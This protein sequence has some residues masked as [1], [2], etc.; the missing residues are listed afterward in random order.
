VSILYNL[1][2]NVDNVNISQFAYKK[3]T[4]TN[5]AYT[6]NTRKRV[7]DEC[8]NRFLQEKGGKSIVVL[9]NKN[10]VKTQD[11]KLIKGMP[12][13]AH[14]TDKKMNILNS[15]LFTIESIDDK[16]MT[17]VDETRKIIMKTAEFHKTFYLGFCITV[18]ASQGATI[19]ENYTI[20][21]WNHISMCERAKYVS[22]SR[23]SSIKKIQIVA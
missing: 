23:S 18:H 10:N 3:D 12:I 21:D 16:E 19:N 13:I 4:Y 15:D 17:I 14:T 9:R 22:L 1:C 6:H 8:M 11:V 5:I 7:N 2:K 20:Y